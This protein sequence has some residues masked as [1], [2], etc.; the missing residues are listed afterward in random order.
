[1]TLP[2]LVQLMQQQLELEKATAQALR[3]ESRDIDHPGIKV[4]V[5]VCAA[6]ATKHATMVTLILEALRKGE[7]SRETFVSTWK[8]RHRGLEAIKDH[9]KRETQMINL[10]KEQILATQDKTLKTLLEHILADEERHH[11][12]L[13]E[14]IWEI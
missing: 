1:M 6:D 13:T 11:K 7:L 8:Q 4:L 12:I 3:K 9:I 2:K 5:E 14:E 10:L